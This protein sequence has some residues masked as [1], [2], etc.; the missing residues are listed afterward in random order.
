MKV[1]S[2]ERS[3][4]ATLAQKAGFIK[5]NQDRVIA[6]RE[7]MKTELSEQAINVMITGG[8][9]NEFQSAKQ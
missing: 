4:E 5:E 8:S 9:G 3:R 2:E 7:T 6:E 1:L